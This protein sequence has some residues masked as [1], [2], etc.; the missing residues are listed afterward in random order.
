MI[1]SFRQLLRANPGFESHGLLTMSLAIGGAKFQTPAQQIS[2]FNQV[3]ERVRTLPGVKSAGVID[4][5]PL[6]GNGSHQPIAVEGRPVLA[7]SDQPEVDVRVI[8]SGYL[9]SL[10]VPLLRGRDFEDGDVAGRPAVVLVSRSMARQFWPGEDPIGKHLTMTFYPGIVR[11]VVG[12]VGDVKSDGLAQT[13]T[14]S[15]LY[16]SLGQLSAPSPGGWGSFPMALVVRS[17][18]PTS[19][20][21][22]VSSAVHQVDNEIPIRDVFT[23]DDLVATS[24]SQQRFRMSLLGAFGALALALAGIGIYSVLSYS[25]K[26]QIPEIGIRLA[27]G[28]GLRDVLR[29]VVIQGMKP[30]LLGI[31]VGVAAALA[32]GRVVA[33]LLYAVKPTDPI[34]F[35]A[36]VALLSLIA[37]CACLVP[38]YR[39]A[40]VDPVVALRYE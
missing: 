21:S 39:A 22:A 14:A 5:L 10:H 19:L 32:L 4:N 1:R 7:M 24:L 35:L 23:M 17:T 12:V 40:K 13:R 31:A 34:T 3:L 11:E 30:T 29:L 8:S 20:A 36:V 33:A 2:F 18:N 27:L 25:V 37:V 16:A 6:S 38:A 9:R 26:R 15:T 28:A